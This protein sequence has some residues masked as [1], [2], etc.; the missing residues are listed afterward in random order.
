MT[1]QAAR[2]ASKGSR[3]IT[4]WMGPWKVEREL[5]AT[6]AQVFCGARQCSLSADQALLHAAVEVQAL[7]VGEKQMAHG[8]AGAC[9]AH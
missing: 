2:W 5:H 6:L 1:L 9:P 7:G 4:A 3:N 8:R